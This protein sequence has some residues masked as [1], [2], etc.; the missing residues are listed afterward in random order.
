MQCYNEYNVLKTPNSASRF[1]SLQSEVPIW[2]NI[3]SVNG[4][5][6]AS[7]VWVNYSRN[8]FTGTL[9]KPLIVVEG[10]AH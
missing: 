10:Y 8:N 1:N 6:S 2:G 7:T 5:R 3:A 9:R 4:T